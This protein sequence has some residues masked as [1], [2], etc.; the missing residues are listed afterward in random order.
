MTDTLAFGVVPVVD[1]CLFGFQ[2]IVGMSTFLRVILG[3]FHHSLRLQ[4]AI[5]LVHTRYVTLFVHMFS[6]RDWP[7][8]HAGIT[9]P[10]P[11]GNFSR[12]FAIIPITA[13]NHFNFV[14]VI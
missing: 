1:L 7:F 12:G 8:H 11:L 5:L 3:A 10:L 14:I 4:W 6:F 13:W 9:F 2:C